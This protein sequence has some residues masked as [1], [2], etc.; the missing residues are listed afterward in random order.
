MTLIAASGT[1]SYPPRNK[2]DGIRTTHYETAANTRHSDQ[3][4]PPRSPFLATSEE[5][6]HAS[7]SA[8]RHP[9]ATL[10]KRTTGHPPKPTT[11]LPNPPTTSNSPLTS[12]PS[13]S[14]RLSLLPLPPTFS[15][16]YIHSINSPIFHPL[17][18]VVAFCSETVLSVRLR[19]TYWRFPRCG[20]R[21]QQLTSSASEPTQ[22]NR[23]PPPRSPRLATIE[24]TSP[25]HARDHRLQTTAQPQTSS[26]AP[27]EASAASHAHANQ[28]TP[29]TPTTS[30]PRPPPVRYHPHEPYF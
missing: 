28:Q 10:D 26:L 6:P 18:A 16:R 20:L 13:P 30:R 25:S 9:P 19:R 14:Q 22:P 21:Q 23:Q 12:I 24:A 7:P 4:L 5:T 17:P 11:W 15:I 1:N 8:W 3:C 2:Q 27:G 29:T